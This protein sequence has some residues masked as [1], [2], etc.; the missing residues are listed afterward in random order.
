MANYELLRIYWY[1]AHPASETVKRPVSKTAYPLAQTER[2]RNAQKL[3]DQLVLKPN[4]ALRM[5]ELSVSPNQW[6]VKP[7]VARELLKSPRALS[8]EDFD[9]D[10]NQKGVDMRVG[11]DMARLALRDMF[12]P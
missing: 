6:R 4:F 11:M 7:R 12:E 10:I 8:D 1:D 5:G 2:Y 3:F 9:L